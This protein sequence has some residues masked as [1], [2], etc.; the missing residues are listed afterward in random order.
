MKLTDTGLRS[1]W[2]TGGRTWHWDELDRLEDGNAVTRS[3][4]RLRLAPAQRAEVAAL[5]EGPVLEGTSDDH[6]AS[7]SSYCAGRFHAPTAARLILTSAASLAATDLHLEPGPHGTRLR[8]RREGQLD[9]WF[10]LVPRHSA[11]LVAALKGL[12]GCLPYRVDV[13]Q[14]GRIPRAGVCADIR[15]SFIPTRY[16]ERVALRLFG[17]LRTLEEIAPE[18][19]LEDYREV[20][21]APRGLVLVSGPS[22]AGKTTT[23]YAM[24]AHV[25]RSRGGAH[26]SLEDPVEQRL[27]EA[28][29]PVD[30]V[31]LDP[32]RG[33]SAEAMLVA[34]LRQDVDVLCVGEIRTAAEAQLAIEAAHTG[35]LVLAGL[36][37]GSAKEALQRMRDLKVDA[38]LLQS[39]LRGVV[40]QQL[41][42]VP[43]ACGG[44]CAGCQGLGR[45]RRLSASIL[46]VSQ[47]GA[48][49]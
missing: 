14:E 10:A 39:T 25:S 33:R 45:R 18:A 2:L 46:K 41:G 49:R 17:R 48:K 38:A 28:D 24:L 7:L 11:R 3:G 8:L 1:T 20:L 32:S 36:H 30:Q 21:S 44:S 35:R 19:Q 23:L 12:A 42:T 34:A 47:E 31:E 27:R 5:F 13:V 4:E 37:A 26:L 43:C 29:I 40:H 16:G 6:A 22:G 9:D 15:A